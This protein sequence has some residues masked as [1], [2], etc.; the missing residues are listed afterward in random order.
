MSRTVMTKRVV[1]NDT[2]STVAT[3]HPDPMLSDN[4]VELRTPDGKMIGTCLDT[5]PAIL[6]YL[7]VN[8]Y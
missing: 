4:Y 1:D 8:G 7:Q 5:A 2:G 6:L 3:I